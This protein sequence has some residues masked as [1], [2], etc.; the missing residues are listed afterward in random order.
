MCHAV[1]N[2]SSENSETPASLFI[3][4]VKRKKDDSLRGHSKSEPETLQ[5]LFSENSR[6][7]SYISFLRDSGPMAITIGRTQKLMFRR[8]PIYKP[9]EN[10]SFFSYH[11][12]NYMFG[13]SLLLSQITVSSS[14]EK[15]YQF[16][17]TSV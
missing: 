3:F 14:G 6:K 15:G 7:V 16:L 13:V 10:T 5:E 4:S 12:E 8:R 1:M 17:L 2:S 9:F 11:M